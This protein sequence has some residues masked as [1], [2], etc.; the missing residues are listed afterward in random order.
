MRVG[1]RS[2][3]MALDLTDT[4]TRLWAGRQPRHRRSAA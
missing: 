2:E 4:P 3:G 1:R